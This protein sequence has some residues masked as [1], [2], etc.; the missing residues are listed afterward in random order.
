MNTYIIFL[1]IPAV[2]KFFPIEK[3][4]AQKNARVICAGGFHIDNISPAQ[5]KEL[6]EAL[7]QVV[8]N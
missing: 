7:E 2:V 8:W 5:L 6:S 1:L 3:L 4:S